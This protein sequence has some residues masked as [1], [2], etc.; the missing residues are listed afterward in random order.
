MGY[1]ISIL[2]FIDCLLLIGVILVQNSKGGGLAAGL[3]SSNQFLGVRKTTDVLEKATWGFA[4][5]LLVLCLLSAVVSG[6]GSGTVEQAESEL[7]NLPA[8]TIPTTAPTPAP[9]S[10][11]N[12]VSAP[13]EQ[14]QPSE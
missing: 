1:V 3:T 8:A 14:P 4:V 5:A 12:P 9:A 7:T 6:T 10:D 11:F 2:I 13:A